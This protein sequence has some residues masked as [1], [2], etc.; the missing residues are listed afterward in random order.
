MNAVPKRRASGELEADVMAVL[1]DDE[2]SWLIPAEVH[3]R[4][5]HRRPLAYT[6]VMTILTRL[7]EKGMLDRRFEGRAYGY[8]PVQTREAWTAQRML[9]I[10][11]TASD[12]AA[13]LHHFA[14][15]IGK[16]DAS[17]LRRLLEG[18]R[19]K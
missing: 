12:R 5:P 2:E 4:L 1:W 18:K 17:Q 16:R 19:R 14:D 9:D 7:W 11:D 13:A 8:Q 6:T 10:L 3:A 15:E